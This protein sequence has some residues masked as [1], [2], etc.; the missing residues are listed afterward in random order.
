MID[1]YVPDKLIAAILCFI[2]VGVSI[3]WIKDKKI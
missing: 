3:W 1:V 2:I